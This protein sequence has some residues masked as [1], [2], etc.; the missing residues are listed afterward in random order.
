MSSS[1]TKPIRILLIDD[2]STNLQVMSSVL[3]GYGWQ[4][5]V[6]TDGESAIAH[7]DLMPPDLILLDVMMPG[8]DGFET[9]RRLKA[10][11]ATAVIP[12]IFMTALVS[13]AEKLK[14]LSL[15]AVDYITKPFDQ[16][17]VVAR[18]KLH[19]R[20]SQLTH[21]LEEEVADRT[22]ALEQ[23][24]QQLQRAQLQLIQSEKMSALG[25][26]VSGI[27]HEI[28]NPLNFIGGN[29]HF[30]DR[31]M[32]DLC[33]LMDLYDQKFVAD[34]AIQEFKD[35]IEFEHLKQDCLKLA[36]SM[37]EGVKR[38]KEISGSL[39]TYARA[40]RNQRSLYDIHHGLDSTLLLLR[41]RQRA[42][43]QRSAIQIEQH[44]GEIPPLAC[45]PGPLNQ[46]FMNLLSNAIDAIDEQTQ[47]N[48]AKSDQAVHYTIGLRTEV[49]D[50]SVIMILIQDNAGGIPVEIQSKIFSPAFTTKAV[51]KGTGLGLP[52]S[53]QII[54]EKHYGT[55]CFDSQ[56]GEGTTFVIKLPIMTE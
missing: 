48:S 27:G 3:E 18:V 25:Q 34:E 19:L 33:A 52:I 15:G 6:V 51:D 50:D 32:R 23:S 41:H 9:C 1:E 7:I 30:I 53:R 22:Q 39:R 16:D 42:N 56:P 28:N 12:V 49:V 36:D 37:Q 21:R 8:I 24:M 29:L 54:T 14:G 11:P 26:M 38:I 13:S 20:L 44:Y 55:L 35:E 43:E 17:E 31:Y 40:D 10:N 4:T 2:N 5:A 46:V 47:V 45:Y